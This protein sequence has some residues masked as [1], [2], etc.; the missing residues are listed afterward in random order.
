MKVDSTL[1]LVR[2]GLAGGAVLGVIL[3]MLVVIIILL[4]TLWKKKQKSY[5]INKN[6][7]AHHNP[8]Y[9]GKKVMITAFSCLLHLYLSR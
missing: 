1:R 9:E 4:V 6:Y 3:I 5:S 2:I 7:N 8:V